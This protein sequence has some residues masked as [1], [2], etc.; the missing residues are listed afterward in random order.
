[1]AKDFIYIE[2]NQ[3]GQDPLNLKIEAHLPTPI[4]G[5]QLVFDETL[6]RVTNRRIDYNNDI[7]ALFVEVLT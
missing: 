6:Y 2:I 5:D 7:I 3:P 1:M 4:I